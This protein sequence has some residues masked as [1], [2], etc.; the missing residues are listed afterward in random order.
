MTEKKISDDAIV[1]VSLTKSNN[2]N[3]E[4]KSTVL[5]MF[6]SHIEKAVFDVVNEFNLSSVDISVQDYGA[7]DFVIRARTRMAIRRALK[8]C[9]L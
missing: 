6:K 9:V 4:I 5:H 7:L 1:E 8:E 3:I 2:V